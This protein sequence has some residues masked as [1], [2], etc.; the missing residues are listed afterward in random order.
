MLSLLDPVESSPKYLHDPSPVTAAMILER[1]RQRA[2]ERWGEEKWQVNLV[3]EYARIAYAQG[4]ENAT[5][6]NRRTQVIR[7]FESKKC[8]L[9]TAVLL[10][11]AVGC[12]FQMICTTIEVEIEQF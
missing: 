3:R 4:D 6:N 5:P 1:I 11:A 2:V 7:V 12:R 8:T 9:D 10:A